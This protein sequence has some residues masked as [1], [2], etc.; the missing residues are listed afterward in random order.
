MAKKIASKNNTVIGVDPGATTGIF[1]FEEG[2]PK[3]GISFKTFW[4][5]IA[6]FEENKNATFVVENANLNKPTFGY[7]YAI[8]LIKESGYSYANIKKQLLTFSKKG[9]NVGMVKMRTTLYLEFFECMGIKHHAIRPI[10]GMKNVASKKSFYH[11]IDTNKVKSERN[12]HVQD[13]FWTALLYIQHKNKFETQN[14][15]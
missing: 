6:F 1:I 9:Q 11:I 8:N 5:T 14:Q 3:K 15:K 12:Q 2:K 10:K 4:E 13:A 7:E